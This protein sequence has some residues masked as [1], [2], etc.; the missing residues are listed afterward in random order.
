MAV[1]SRYIDLNAKSFKPRTVKSFVRRQGRI[2]AGQ[3]RAFQ[4]LLPTYQLPN[5]GIWDFAKLFGRQAPVWLEIGFGNGDTLLNLAQQYPQIDFVG[6]E[7]HRP[8]IG[9]VL[10]TAERLGINNLRVAEGDAVAL[11][12]EHCPDASLDRVLLLFPDPWHKTKHHK[13]RIVQP[14]FIEMVAQKL[15][16]GGVWHLATD[17]QEY[18]EL[19]L[20]QISLY[21]DFINQ[22]ADNRF[23]AAPDYRCE[24]RFER[25]GLRLNHQIC[26]LL[27]SRR[28]NKSNGAKI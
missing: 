27:F 2:T 19:M 26:D 21:N 20:K 22:A 1:F 6:I 18:G 23:V 9:Q 28:D 3:Q 16:T 5:T 12:A 10:V 4:E 7:V 13:R 17:W 24:T 14:E 15:T 25:R 11:L 8:G